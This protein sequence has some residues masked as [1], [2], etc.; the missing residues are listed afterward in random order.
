MTCVLR[1]TVRLRDGSD[2]VRDCALRLRR[3]APPEMRIVAAFAERLADGDTHSPVIIAERPF[4][5]SQSVRIRIFPEN[6][7][8]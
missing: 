5:Q 6:F 3:A 7:R 1:L 8:G 2:D 4:E